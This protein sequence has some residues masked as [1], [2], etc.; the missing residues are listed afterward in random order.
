MD[1]HDTIV[2]IAS[3]A[4][5][6]PRG[7]IRISGARAIDVARAIAGESLPQNLTRATAV[8]GSIALDAHRQL[9]AQFL[10]WPGVRSYTREPTVEIHTFGSPPLLDMVV[11]LACQ[12]GARLAAPGEFT[13]RAFLAGRIDLTQAE[14]VLGVIDATSDQHLQSALEQLAGGLRAPLAGLREELLLLLADLEA[15]LDFADEDIQFISPDVLARRLGN[16]R[17]CIVTLAEQLDSRGVT[18][19]LPTVVLA[20]AANAGKSSLFNALVRRF[21]NGEQKPSAI[22]SPEPGATRDYLMRHV[23]IRGVHC[24]LIDTAGVERLDD[25]ISPR[26]F[27]QAMTSKVRDEATLVL[28]CHDATREGNIEPVGAESEIV[29]LTKTDLSS[30]RIEH[31]TTT[32]ATSAATGEGLDALAA[33]IVDWFSGGDAAAV[34]STAER[35]R[36][37]LQ[38]ALDALHNAMSL[39]ATQHSEELV[40]TELRV[41]LDEL[42][43]IAG[44]VYNDDV[45]DRVFS[46]FCIG[47]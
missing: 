25:E 4:G 32:V 3:A 8:P 18:G 23:N 7:V 21:G 17:E 34:A 24:E 41:A 6:A 33:I 30:Q 13:L 26:H 38:A 35:S 43:Q 44:V 42:G 9:P 5:G 10:V 47:K 1:T 37:C 36:L 29:V 14:A 12:S 39:A 31:P 2:A 28:F 46:R 15:G 45:L 19:G 11:R 20:G 22:E 16:V 27:A 40:A